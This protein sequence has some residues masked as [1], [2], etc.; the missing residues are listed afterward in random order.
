MCTFIYA[1]FCGNVLLLWRPCTLK[2]YITFWQHNLLH[3]DLHNYHALLFYS[4][5]GTSAT[6]V[7][8]SP[9]CDFNG[10]KFSTEGLSKVNKN[11]IN[12]NTKH[13]NLQALVQEYTTLIY[14]TKNMWVSF[15]YATF[16]VVSTYK[17]VGRTPAYFI[18]QFKF[19]K[20]IFKVQSNG[21]TCSIATVWE[22]HHTDGLQVDLRA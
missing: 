20:L 11:V 6:A 15:F 8:L 7:S 18:P 9:I 2:P 16:W 21:T 3:P 14:V 1:I 5:K 22:T 4:N 19:R 10:F 13:N 12:F 17:T